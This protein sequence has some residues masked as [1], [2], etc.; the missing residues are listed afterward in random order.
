MGVLTPKSPSRK[1]ATDLLYWLLKFM[2]NLK[3][4]GIHKC[5]IN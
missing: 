2:T 4:L 1:Y 5:E 3:Y